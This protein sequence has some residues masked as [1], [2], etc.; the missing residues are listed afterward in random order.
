MKIRFLIF[1][2]SFSFTQSLDSLDISINTLRSIVENA[3]RNGQRVLI[4]DFTGLDCPP[5]NWASLAVSDMLDEFP[6]TLISLQWHLTAYTPDQ[7][8]FNECLISGLSVGPDEAFETRGN[9]YGW[10][11]I[12][13]IPIE[14]FNGTQILSGANSGDW[15][16][17]TYVPIYQDLVGSYSPYEIDIN[18]IIDNLSVNYEINVTL[19][20]TFDTQNH[21]LYLFIVEDNILSLWDS[22]PNNARNVVRNWKSTTGL[23]INES[24][25]NQVFSGNFSL[26]T[27]SWNPDSIKIISVVQD[28]YT[29]EVFQVQQKNINDFDYDLDGI[30]G[31][32][33]NCPD[34]Y[35]PDQED[36]DN[37]Q[38]GDACDICDNANVW[39]VGN[40]NGEIDMNQNYTV[41]IFDVLALSDLIISNNSESCGYQIGDFNSDGSISLLDIFQLAGFIMQN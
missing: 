4:D 9:L 10:D 21:Y 5:C 8:D 31:D 11:D 28:A 24:G 41:D 25:Q 2:L 12:S 13:A 23:E 34:V 30:T 6:E 20:S 17:N 27:S 33:D 29:S 38:L 22:G 15:A 39:V 19:D 40:I 1:L 14:V 32:E 3:S 35:N 26:D 16:Y 36:S 18:G 7:Y 37:D